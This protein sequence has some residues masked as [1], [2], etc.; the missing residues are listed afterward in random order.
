MLKNSEYENELLKKGYLKVALFSEEE[1]DQL[2]R[3]SIKLIQQIPKV[4][5]KGF[6]SVGRIPDSRI[7]NLSTDLIR[8]HFLPRLQSLF[9][10]NYEFVSGVHL[11]KMP[12]LQGTLNIHQD[13]S[14][15]DERNFTSVYAW[16]PLQRTNIL[17]GT[18]HVIPGS[19]LF[20][21]VHRTL[22]I[23][24]P[25]KAYIPPLKK[26]EVALPVKKGE[27]VLFH[28]ALMHS[29]PVNLSFFKRLAINC[30][31]KP[32]AA[33]LVHYFLDENTA[34]GK[35][36]VF[37]ITPDFYYCEDILKRPDEHKYPYKGTETLAMPALGEGEFMELCK[38]FL[39]PLVKKKI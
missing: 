38:K 15:V 28:S 23:P 16:M 25:F 31:I 34:A 8:L 24:N 13:S 37:E 6:V 14:M 18:L 7:R 21:N 22:N 32:K 39:D 33:P 12:G 26:F 2:Y 10:E 30:F 17:N 3:D 29:S 36:D 5:L 1:T 27:V 35:V 9:E 4:F 20:G 19:H 11:I